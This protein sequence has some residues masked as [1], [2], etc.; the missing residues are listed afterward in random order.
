MM[1]CIDETA[2]SPISVFPLSP[3]TTVAGEQETIEW[4]Q[5]LWASVPDFPARPVDLRPEPI[6]NPR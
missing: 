5:G 6:G 3:L 1:N 2:E 4:L